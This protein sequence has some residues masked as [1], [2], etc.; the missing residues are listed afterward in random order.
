MRSVVATWSPPACSAVDRFGCDYEA[1]A[2]DGGVVAIR[3]PFSGSLGDVDEVRRQLVA[4]T[5]AARR[6]MSGP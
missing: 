1:A 5:Y 6:A 4:Q 2:G 3:V